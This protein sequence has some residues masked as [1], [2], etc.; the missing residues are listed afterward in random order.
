MKK[1]LVAIFI[2]VMMFGISAKAMAAAA[3]SDVV[4]NGCV[5]TTDIA[6]SAVT[7]AKVG[8]S[9]VTN[10]KIADYA[11]TNAKIANA[12]VTDAKI[13]GPISV[14]KIERPASVFMVATSGGNFTTISAALASLPTPNTTP[15]LIKVMPGTYTESNG[16]QMKS[17]VHLQGSGREVTTV[18]LQDRRLELFDTSDNAITGLTIKGNG[19][20]IDCERC[21]KLTVSDNSITGP[22]ASVSSGCGVLAH[23]STSGTDNQV[24]IANN[25][26]SGLRYGIVPHGY[27]YA[28]VRDNI[29]KGNWHGMDIN[30]YAS[31]ISN[32][33]GNIISDSSEYGIWI[34]GSPTVFNNRI[35]NSGISDLF[36]L[37]VSSNPNISLNVYDTFTGSGAVGAYNV[38]Q[39][40][41]PAPLQ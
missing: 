8:T 28:T 23:S 24:V 5:G 19:D 22:G 36:L 6:N 2:G 14:S 25:I 38:K 35:T 31:G 30:S 39:D 9:A 3:A 37:G 20:I 27:S 34:N 32:T 33:T 15:V 41:T 16:I 29:I 12:A 11:V 13:T 10:T 7:E 26:V 1:Y 17:N 21:T 40:G 4:C 18:D